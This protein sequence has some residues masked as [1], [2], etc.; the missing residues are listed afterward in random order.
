[1]SSLQAPTPRSRRPSSPGAALGRKSGTN[2]REPVT[3]IVDTGADI[4]VVKKSVGDRFDY[5]RVRGL[6]ASPTTGRGGIIVVSGITTEFEVTDGLG[7]RKSTSSSKN[8]GVKSSDS[9]S[10]LLGME[11]IADAKAE[12]LWNPGT[13]SGSLRV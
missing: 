3:W 4:S 11:Q 9:G 6:S 8:V 13:R 7:T 1:M 10:N 12:L 2:V 5:A